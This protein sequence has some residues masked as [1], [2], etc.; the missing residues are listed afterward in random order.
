VAGQ[1]DYLLEK[2]SAAPFS[3]VPFRHVEIE[4]FLSPEHFDAI[5]A[6]PQIQLPTYETTEQLLEGLVEQG[7]IFMHFPGCVESIKQYLDFVNGRSQP[8]WH[9][10]TEGFGI[11]Y[12]LMDCRSSLIDDL[13]ALF[14][15]DQLKALLQ[16]KFG[17]DRAVTVDAGLQ[18]YLDGYEIS[19]HPDIRRKALTWMLNINPGVN[20]EEYEFHTHYLRLKPQWA[21]IY[22]FWKQNP[23]FDRDWLPWDWC[24]TVKRQRNNN[25]IIF[26]S[27]AD[28]TIHAVKARYDHL[29][30]QRT[31]MYGNLWYEKMPLPKVRFE[32]F[33]IPTRVMALP[34]ERVPAFA[35][36]ENVASS[37]VS[38]VRRKLSKPQPS[39]F[40]AV[41]F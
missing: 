5:T 28:D 23:D 24:E 21:F 10:A 2:I 4:N 35:R 15:S 7:Y 34:P 41:E 18:K 39:G 20:S 32:D 3:E 27:P 11:V 12:R 25:S 13:D 40:R 31:Q 29:S 38:K 37:F 8:D 26:F 14:R 30:V 33:D 16:D 17:I 36:M 6:A 9:K 19:P 1:F 22:E